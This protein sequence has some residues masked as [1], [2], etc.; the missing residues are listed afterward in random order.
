[1]NRLIP[2]SRPT[3]EPEEERAVVKVLQSKEIAQGR[4]VEEFEQGVTDYIGVK[5]YKTQ[6]GRHYPSV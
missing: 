1:M 4:R 3:I 2:Q 6:Q 5:C